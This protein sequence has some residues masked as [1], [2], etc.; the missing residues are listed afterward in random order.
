MMNF[1]QKL[2]EN[3]AAVLACIISLITA[4][5][6]LIYVIFT[7]HQMKLAQKS[8]DIMQKESLQNK[9]PCLIFN[10]PEMI[11]DPSLDN[12]RRFFNIRFDAENMGDSLAIA[13]FCICHLELKNITCGNGS[14]NFNMEISP[15]FIPAIKVSGQKKISI[16]YE[17]EGIDYLY[18]DL[19]VSSAKNIARIAASPWEHHLPST[20]I[21]IQIFY[22]N[23]KGQWFESS[24][25]YEV[26]WVNQKFTD[27]CGIIQVKKLSLEKEKFDEN[28][29]YEIIPAPEVFC[30][31]ET[32]MVDQ[33]LVNDSLDPYKREWPDI[34]RLEENCR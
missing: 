6:T 31:F 24:A 34:F 14:K 23:T 4:A 7:H 21:A 1:L 15:F 18:K 10:T 5:I 3:Y 16:C 9:Q 26:W 22:K 28:E 27:E 30:P 19:A 2:N 33:K 20:N 25:K 17:N 11:L 8:V 13:I 32:K 12:G 29:S